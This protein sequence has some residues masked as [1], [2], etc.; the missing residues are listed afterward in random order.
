MLHNM[1]RPH[2]FKF[3]GHSLRLMINDKDYILLTLGVKSLFLF[4]IIYRL[5]LGYDYRK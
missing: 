2:F 3:D 1:P 4:P 5:S